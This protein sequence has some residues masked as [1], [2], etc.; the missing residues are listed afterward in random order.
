MQR[1]SAKS[2][3]WDFAEVWKIW[4]AQNTEE[5]S[6]EDQDVVDAMEEDVYWLKGP[7]TPTTPIEEGAGG[8]GRGWGT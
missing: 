1:H 6:D 3:P 2:A 7:D 8:E 5:L 4:L